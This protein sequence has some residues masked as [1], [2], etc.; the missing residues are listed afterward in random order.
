MTAT[1]TVT[2]RQ[3]AQ[4]AALLAG[5]D[6][7][8][9]QTY[10]VPVEHL[11]RLLALPWTAVD[12]AG[13]ASCV[14]PAM[15]GMLAQR[16]QDGPA[17][18]AAAEDI[19]ESRRAREEERK[20]REREAHRRHDLQREAEQRQREEREREA[21]QRHREQQ[22]RY[23]RAMET[24]WAWAREHGSEHVRLLHDEE[25]RWYGVAQDEWYA[26]HTPD[27][28]ARAGEYERDDSSYVPTADEILA[29]RDARLLEGDTLS[30]ARLGTVYEDVDDPEGRRAVLITLT[31]PLGATTLMR[32]V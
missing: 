29:L 7:A 8:R 18:L 5:E 14:I 24:L 2:L 17:A 21:E 3:E 12:Q 13:D 15:E 28:Y 23:E 26:A 16:P 31:G 10:D 9:E 1:I 20:E 27:G 25:L 30:N 22:A 32:V 11:P 6:A 19:A 4:R